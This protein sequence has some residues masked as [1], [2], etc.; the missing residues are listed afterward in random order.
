[1]FR[2]IQRAGYTTS[3]IG[4]LHWFTGG[5]WNREFKSANDYHRALALDHVI[6]DVGAPPSSPNEHNPYALHLE[7]LGLLKA[8]ATD[9]HDR[10]VRWEYEPRASVVQ[11]ENYHD[12]F[13]T[14][15]AID[16]IGRQPADKPLCVVVSMHSPH[17]PL[18]APGKYATM[19]DPPSLRLPDNVPE[20]FS[21]DRH[22]IDSAELRRMLANYLGM[23]AL[24]DD[25]VGRL[26]EALKKRGTWENSLFVLTADHGEMMGAHGALTKGKFYEESARVPLV[27]RWPGHVQPARSKAPVQMFDVYP[28]V[29]EAIGSQLTLGRFAK[30]LLPIASGKASTVRELAISEIGQKAPLDIMARDARYKWWAQDDREFLFDLD[31]DPLEMRNLADS[32]EHQAIADRMRTQLITHLRNTQVNVAEGYKPRVQRMREAEAAAASGKSAPRTSSEKKP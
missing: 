28:T 22:T 3:Q 25:N 7:K 8:V 9:T 32:S 4:K 13:L 10:L 12:T 1:M 30:S 17:P 6:D 27:L 14:D 31:S 18:D 21:R 11:A 23:I 19:F 15:E 20:T 2:D 24:V 26:T 16:L 29:V 5:G